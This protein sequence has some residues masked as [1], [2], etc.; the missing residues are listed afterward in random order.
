MEQ[1][2]MYRAEQSKLSLQMTRQSVKCTNHIPN[3]LN[4]SNKN[5]RANKLRL[6]ASNCSDESMARLD[7]PLHRRRKAAS[8]SSI[9]SSLNQFVSQPRQ[10]ANR[11]CI[12]RFTNHPRL[13]RPGS[14]PTS[15]STAQ[16]PRS[17]S[18][19]QHRKADLSADIDRNKNQS[20]NRLDRN[21]ISQAPNRSHEVENE[22]QN[23]NK[24]RDFNGQHPIKLTGAQDNGQV[25]GQ[26]RRVSSS[27]RRNQHIEPSTA[28]REAK[29]R[30]ATKASPTGRQSTGTPR[31]TAKRHEEDS[32]N[33]EN[34]LRTVQ[35]ADQFY[36]SYQKHNSYLIKFLC[37]S[38]APINSPRNSTFLRLLLLFAFF[39]TISAAPR[40]VKIG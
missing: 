36:S 26:I 13:F 38:S 24:V 31:T 2:K 34:G 27:I 22:V 23:V 29:I 3:S 8:P 32:K 20:I 1:A 14:R 4:I 18:D 15:K 7:H 39:A 40:V 11:E 9:S 35:D 19:G 6:S 10:A 28:R 16:H 21:V 30:R 37:K 25:N 12:N 5:D 33:V 17:V